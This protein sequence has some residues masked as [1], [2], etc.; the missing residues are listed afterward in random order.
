MT[1]E[2]KI[3]KFPNIAAIEAEAA[4]WV[5]RFDGGDVSAEEYAKFQSWLNQSA[6]HR[7]AVGEYGR[8][9]A[10]FS[11]MKQL[12]AALEAGRKASAQD[13]RPVATLMSRRWLAYAAGGSLAAVL[14][15]A[16]VFRGLQE[17]PPIVQSYETAIGAQKNAVLP[18]GSTVVL[19]TN[20]RIDVKIFRKRREVRLVRGEAYFE[21][22]HDEKRPFTVVAGRGQVRD[23]GTAFE[24]QLLNSSVSVSVATGSVEISALLPEGDTSGTV[25]QRLA[26][27][28]AGQN[29]LFDRKIER[30]ERLSDAD[31]NRRLAWRQGV[32]IYAGEPLATVVTD[33]SRYSTLT[34][35]L[36]PKLRD[37]RVGG[38]FKISQIRDVFS[39]LESNFGIRAEWI[40]DRQ[41]R[42]TSR[43][44]GGG[45]QQ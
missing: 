40:S 12:A 19:N 20:T 9:L 23:I 41:V 26:I 11:N 3:A 18:D 39:A 31:M 24:V 17:P 28:N 27:V 2:P 16:I 37:R 29:A 14:A 25:P 6:V 35:E 8:L 5:A 32:L 38:S 43:H 44:G 4:A 30:L 34:I 21:V 45:Q 10:E 13:R 33:I 15:A 7:H 22:V 42:I 36:D 1:D